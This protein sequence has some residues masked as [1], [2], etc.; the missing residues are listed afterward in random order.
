MKI[1]SFSAYN[2]QSVVLFTSYEKGLKVV[3]KCFSLSYINWSYVLIISLHFEEVLS[4]YGEVTT[5]GD[6]YLSN[7]SRLD[8]QKWTT[9]S[10]SFLS[11]RKD[12]KRSKEK[13]TTRSLRVAYFSL[14]LKRKF[15][16]IKLHQRYW[17]DARS[18]NP[19]SCAVETSRIVWGVKV[20]ESH[21]F[22]LVS[23]SQKRW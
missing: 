15:N 2:R 20:T 12:H 17:F 23:W 5:L 19:I 18:Y 21:S 8:L 22:Q 10:F 4:D 7:L 1:W 11:S 6:P 9:V 14:E 13:S 3:R 16:L